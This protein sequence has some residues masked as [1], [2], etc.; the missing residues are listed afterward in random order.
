MYMNFTL[1]LIKDLQN[2]H[3]STDN[4]PNQ[5][6]IVWHTASVGHTEQQRTNKPE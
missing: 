3:N 4:G 6:R 5:G 2:F 1:Y